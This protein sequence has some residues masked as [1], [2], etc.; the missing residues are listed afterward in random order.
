MCVFIFYFA[1]KSR[2]KLNLFGIQ[3]SL[4]F[5]KRFENE[6]GISIFL[7]IL[8]QNPTPPGYPGQQGALTWLL[9]STADCHPHAV[10]V[11]LG[12]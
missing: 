7:S 3:K 1:Y 9:P 6:N 10:S 8:G 11:P 5:I 2:S 12:A 4:Q